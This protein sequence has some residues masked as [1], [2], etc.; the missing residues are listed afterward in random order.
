MLNLT[1][2]PASQAQLALGVTDL[3]GAIREALHNMLTFAEL[4]S[5]SDIIASARALASIAARTNASQAMIGGAPYLMA[6][7]IKALE[8]EGIA[9]WFA[10]SRRRS[11]EET[12]PDGSVMKTQSFFHEGFIRAVG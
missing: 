5:A 2:H 1:Q 4:P 8:A 11:V 9:P 12:R 7:L 6:P 3:Q 10:F